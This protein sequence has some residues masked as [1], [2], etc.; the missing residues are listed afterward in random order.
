M[1][2]HDDNTA[3]PV[4]IDVINLANHVREPQ[5]FVQ[6][7]LQRLL[8]QPDVHAV[9]IWMHDDE[10]LVCLDQQGFDRPPSAV[11]LHRVATSGIPVLME[12]PEPGDNQAGDG[13][14]LLA[15]IPLT[16]SGE[17]F[18]VLALL[19]DA[20]QQSGARLLYQAVAGH[21]GL[22]LDRMRADPAMA[23]H[24]VADQAWEEFLSHAAHE[25]KNPLASIKGY[26]DLLGRRA[27]KDPADPYRK[28]LTIISQQIARTNG[29][30]E[31]LSDMARVGAGRLRIDRHETDIATIVRSSVEEHQQTTEEHQLTLVGADEPLIGLCDMVR[32]RQVVDVMLDNATKFSAQ[33][34]PVNVHLQQVEELPEAM[35]SVRDRG[36]G[37]PTGEHERVF[38]RFFR[39][40]NVSGS[41]RGLGL[42]LFVA[43]AIVERHG[44]RMWLESP[45]G[46]GTTCRVIL[47]LL[48]G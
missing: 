10:R 40:S 27:A 16:A 47:P 21:L 3:L 41:Y 35:I 26:A 28:G 30:M 25:I 48:A 1:T 36:I 19:T 14:H 15:F 46:E 33:G 6:Q 11:Q 12:L 32:V 23:G 9:G 22:V 18:G 24:S 13:K 45:P 42:G 39:G 38:E 20:P 5:D 7:V 31:Q 29:L 37:V 17:A 34:G 4:L 8:A 44:G 2:P 43:R